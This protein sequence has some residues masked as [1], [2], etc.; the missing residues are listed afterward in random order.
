VGA[1][2]RLA[3]TL[4]SGEPAFTAE[5]VP[6]PGADGDAVREL[7]A[8]LPPALDAVVVADNYEEIGP[9]A[10]ACS[11]IL[12]AAGIEPVLTI[13]TRDRNRIAL[14]SDVLGAAMLGVTNV[15]CLSGDHQTLGVCP[16]AAGAFDIDST[17]L[18]QAL[19]AMR[20]EGVL[21]GDR[22]LQSGPAL[23]VGAVA[24][25]Y[26]RPP[27]LAMIGL[28]KKVEAGADFLITEPVFD[29]EGFALWMSAVREAGLHERTHIIAGV[30]PL[31]SAEQAEHLQARQGASSIPD[32]VI[33][34]LRSSSDPGREGVAIS[35]EIATRVTAIDGVRGVHAL[36][37]RA[38]GAL[39][40]LVQQ[41]AP[42]RSEA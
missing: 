23:F 22:P 36:C 26:L 33:A 13:S 31:A 17:Q 39:G 30:R 11:S 20:D 34:R 24:H 15:L 10:L 16:E 32:D 1:G 19:A 18:V 29:V 38:N 5:C 37:G 40:E 7:A 4:R 27:E 8:S 42:S 41:I 14:Q 25:P 21:L 2:T 6:P 9:S 28:R 3:D 35:A 12:A